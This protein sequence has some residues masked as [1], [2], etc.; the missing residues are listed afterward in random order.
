M[1]PQAAAHQRNGIR[2][3]RA[4]FAVPC[5]A[6]CRQRLLVKP[7][8]GQQGDQRIESQQARSGPGNR[9]VRPLTLRFHAQVRPCLLKSHFHLPPADEPFKDLLWC[10]GEFCREQSLRRELRLWITHQDPAHRHRRYPGVIPDT[11]PRHDFDH[12]LR[13]TIPTMHSQRLPLSPRRLCH[14]LKRWQPPPLLAWSPLLSGQARW[15]QAHR[16]P[17]P[18]E[19]VSRP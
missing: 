3:G 11:C 8:L 19:G 14:L 2:K 7:A 15:G 16:A 18:S 4:L 12:S 9:F 1:T 5:R 17:R 10:G 13:L 6:S